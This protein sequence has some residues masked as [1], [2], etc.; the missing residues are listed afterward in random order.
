M[1]LNLRNRMNSIVFNDNI[2]RSE[3][4]RKNLQKLIDGY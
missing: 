4:Q 3:S 2:I 1:N